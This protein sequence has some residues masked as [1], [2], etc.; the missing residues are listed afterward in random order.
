MIASPGTMEGTKN[1]LA[2]RSMNGTSTALETVRKTVLKTIAGPI[3]ISEVSGAAP[4]R[5]QIDATR[6]YKPHPYADLLPRM[7]D[8][9]YAALKRSLGT[10]PQTDPIVLYK[11]MI[12]DGRHRYRALRELKIL[13]RYTEFV[14]T[15]T[16]ALAF[17]HARLLHRHLT[18]SQLACC[19]VG[20]KAVMAEHAAER[21]KRG[22]EVAPEEQKGRARDLA[23]D[24]VG[25]SGK[26]VDQAEKILERDPGLFD[27]V[28]EGIVPMARA[29]Q[30][31]VKRDRVRTMETQARRVAKLPSEGLGKWEILPDDNALLLPTIPRR[32]ARLIFLDPKYNINLDGYRDDETDDLPPAEYYGR[33]EKCFA[34][35]AEILT[36]DGSI[37]VLI[38]GANVAEVMLLLKKAGLHLRQLITWHE[39]FAVN[40]KGAFAADRFICYFTRDPRKFVFNQEVFL[41]P[42]DRETVHD[43][44]RATKFAEGGGRTWSSTWGINPKIPRLPGTSK[45]RIPE[46]PTQLPLLLLRAIVLGM[47]DPGD[48]VLDA[49]SGSATTG[50]AAIESGRNYIGIERVKKWVNLSALR[51]RGVTPRLA[52][53]LFVFPESSPELAAE[54]S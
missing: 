35:C 39:D 9:Q 19:A 17:V 8:A 26:Y 23:G 48:T 42:A 51:L 40:Q 6:E 10:G 44:G 32:K 49:F 5:Q 33:L 37:F 28:K 46:F 7:S 24:F 11:G 16:E 30:F 54:A 21:M 18:A 3:T 14:G 12:L 4:P 43:D 13:P 53:P 52:A 2:R 25:V 31:L 20:I 47:S 50:H 22:G 29:R 38:N 34:E 36:A 45:E 15:D 1:K 41:R 27:S